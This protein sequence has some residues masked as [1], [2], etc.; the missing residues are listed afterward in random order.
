MSDAFQNWQS[1]GYFI[2]LF[3]TTFHVILSDASLTIYPI[4]GEE[5]VDSSVFARKWR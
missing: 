2:D 4:A 3:F 5:E 1:N